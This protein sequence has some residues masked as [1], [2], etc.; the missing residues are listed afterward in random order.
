MAPLLSRLAQQHP[1]DSPPDRL[2]SGRTITPDDLA[3]YLPTSNL[4]GTPGLLPLT[5]GNLLHVAR[6][7]SLV[8]MLAPEEVLLGGLSRFIRYTSGHESSRSHRSSASFI[9]SG[10]LPLSIPDWGSSCV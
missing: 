1:A 9:H 5:H 8:T 7:I 6:A 2:S 4:I 3:V 10:T